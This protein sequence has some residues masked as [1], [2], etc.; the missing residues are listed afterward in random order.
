M[1][2]TMS[3][4]RQ[5]KALERLRA[6]A[7]G[8]RV[9]EAARNLAVARARRWGAS[10]SQIGHALGVSTQAAHRKFKTLHYDTKTGKTWHEPSL[11]I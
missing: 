9:A 2:M 11:P 10:W 3:G 8:V 6:T 4:V 1:F 7:E 5:G